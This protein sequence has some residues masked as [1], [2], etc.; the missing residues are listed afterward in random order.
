MKAAALNAATGLRTTPQAGGTTQSKTTMPE[1][2]RTESSATPA[3][4]EP[5]LAELAARRA[6]RR[7]PA[8]R[9]PAGPMELVALPLFTVALLL[10]VW[11]ILVR[12]YKVPVSLLPA[13]SA[14]GARLVETFPTLLQH[15]VPTTIET[16]AS[17]A[18]ASVAGVMLAILLTYS[19]LVN[20]AL[21]PSVVF[22]QLI[23]KV[24]L[25][26]LF[27]V[28]MG[29]GSPARL[30]F[31]VFIAFFPV[32]V[33]TMAGLR[34]TPPDMLRLC[35]GLTA[36]PWQVFTSVRLP[37]A[38]PHIFSGMKIAVT[39]SMIG[40]IVAE[41]ISAQEGLGYL[42]V[43]ASSQADT[44]LILAAILVLCTMGLVLYALVV[45]AEKIA[46]RLYGAH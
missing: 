39:F 13:P 32:V 21:Y 24:A 16:V 15:T 2:L 3:P 19:R 20:S 43:F 7:K 18:L 8:A 33:A 42:I 26:P 34:D 11:E 10:G 29:I 5:S 6:A 45:W 28:W 38:V 27:I 37:Y 23:P 44:A 14:I 40:V 41:F 22:F 36:T 9:R 17:F 35:R 30:A 4:A 31:A 1:P 12:Q 46:L 25:A